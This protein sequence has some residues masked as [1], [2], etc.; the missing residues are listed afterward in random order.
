MQLYGFGGI[1]LTVYLRDP[2]IDQFEMTSLWRQEEEVLWLQVS[3][4]DVE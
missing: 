4:G 3:M 2:K 1:P